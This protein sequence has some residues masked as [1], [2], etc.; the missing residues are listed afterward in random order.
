LSGLSVSLVVPSYQGSHNLKRLL[1]ALEKQDARCDWEVVVVLDGSSDDS[2]SVCEDFAAL[3]PLKFVARKVNLGRSQT[4]NEG[5]ELASK[6]V[7]VRCDDDLEPGVHFVQRFSDLL[8]AN[9]NQ[10]VIGICVNQ[11]QPGRYQKKYGSL[12]DKRF[13][14]AAFDCPAET[15]WHYWAGNCAVTREVFDRVG[16]YDAGFRAYGWEDV[17]WGYR[18]AQ[19][20]VP[21]NIPENFKVVHHLA[22]I[23][24]EKRCERALWSGAAAAKFHAKHSL[25]QKIPAKLKLWNRLVKLATPIAGKNLGRVADLLLI[26]LPSSLAAK[27]IDFAVE[28]SFNRGYQDSKLHQ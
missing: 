25:E 26:L 14:K 24:A 11:F 6:Q 28:A 17:D 7:L 5:F 10:G 21:I 19:L 2:A 3:L 23:N 16:A 1:N 27:F 22:A 20:G 8:T 18:L 15:R 13:S 9:P 12:A 4:L